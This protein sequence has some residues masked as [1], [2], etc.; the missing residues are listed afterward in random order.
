MILY[1]IAV[2]QSFPEVRM[3][4]MARR[5]D[6]D[7]RRSVP[8]FTSE[9]GKAKRL[10]IPNNDIGRGRQHTHLPLCMMIR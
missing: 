10:A 6:M 4:V 5:V 2:V 8:S 9:V 7:D 1:V 3:D